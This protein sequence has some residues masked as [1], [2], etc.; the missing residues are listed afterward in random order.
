MVSKLFER[1]AKSITVTHVEVNGQIVPAMLT[2][3]CTADVV[4]TVVRAFMVDAQFVHSLP[5]ELVPIMRS[6][7]R[8][9]ESDSLS[10]R[11]SGLSGSG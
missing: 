11:L 9:L 8:L 2:L 3:P 6:V 10:F 1:V 7:R 5:D 4:P